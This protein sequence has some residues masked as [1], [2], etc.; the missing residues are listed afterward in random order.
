MINYYSTIGFIG[1]S[2]R[3]LPYCRP[4]PLNDPLK[5]AENSWRQDAESSFQAIKRHLV[6]LI[7]LAYPIPY[8]HTVVFTDALAEAAGTMVQQDVAG[9]FR[10]V[11]FF[12]KRPEFSQRSYSAFD[13]DLLA[14]FEGKRHFHHFLESREFHVI[15]DHKLLTQA[16]G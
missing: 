9:E 12:S 4:P 15:T 13:R 14:I 16:M 2:P 10:L 8:A 7:C 11:A 5:G 1:L 3:P 6:S